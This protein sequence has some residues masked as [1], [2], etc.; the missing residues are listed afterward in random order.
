MS[1]LEGEG[2][3][4]DAQ[5]RKQ[6]PRTMAGAKVRRIAFWGLWLL[7]ALVASSANFLSRRDQAPEVDWAPLFAAHLGYWYLWAAVYLI[8][9]RKA[10][11]P[12]AVAIAPIRTGVQILGTVTAAV[13]LFA[14]YYAV[15]NYT[16]L[17]KSLSIA[18]VG[19]FLF[20]SAH[21]LSFQGMS[22]FIA[23]VMIMISGQ[24][25]QDRL[26]RDADRARQSA[27]LENEKLATALAEARVSALRGQ[28]H[29]HFIF[30]ALNGIASLIEARNN[31]LAYEAINS[32]SSLLRLTFRLVERSA[33]SLDEEMSLVKATLEIGEIRF[34]DRLA[35]TIDLPDQLCNELIP[36]FLL[37]PIVENSL[38]HA[39]GAT[40][41]RTSIRIRAA[42]A[43][44]AI[45]LEVEDDGPGAGS[46]AKSAAGIGLLNLRRRLELTYG[47][48][49][50]CEIEAPKSGGFKTVLTIPKAGLF[51]RMND[52]R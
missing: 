1:N 5:K 49:A 39:V 31:E 35:W 7:L 51:V 14:G 2:I 33:V 41:S 27:A 11:L 42:D 48:D 17:P 43:G 34:G 16:L 4:R 13:A 8:I 12:S 21:A 10:P 37:Q 45:R 44:N 38:R 18:G 22:A 6:V 40:L 28:I 36:P 19:E 26:A 47:D 30:N 52:D 46:A 50:A 29:P 32:L 15:I 24:I 25:A 3:G 9:E 20:G 23:S